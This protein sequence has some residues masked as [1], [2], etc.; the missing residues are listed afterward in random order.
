MFTLPNSP[1]ALQPHPGVSESLTASPLGAR[2]LAQCWT[3]AVSTQCVCQKFPHTF[4]VSTVHQ[5]VKF[6]LE[7]A[8]FRHSLQAMMFLTTDTRIPEYGFKL[9]ACFILA[10]LVFLG[11]HP[12][13]YAGLEGMVHLGVC[14]HR[15]VIHT[16]RMLLCGLR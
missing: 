10:R 12:G 3:A 13:D 8:Y 4:Y 7:S 1:P 15:S 9:P 6:S 2:Y 16:R 5:E 11:R 14:Q